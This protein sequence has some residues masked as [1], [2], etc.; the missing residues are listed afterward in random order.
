M[1]DSSETGSPDHAQELGTASARG[2]HIAAA[3][4]KAA[5]ELERRLEATLG[6]LELSLAKYGVLHSL[7]AAE[8]PL[9]LSDLAARLACV[10]SNITQLVD[11]LE[12]E[13]LVKRIDDPSDRRSVLAELTPK[14]Q[15]LERAG[16]EAIRSVHLEIASRVP[17]G[18]VP[19]LLRGLSSLE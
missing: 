2:A 18:G 19:D 3:I 4:R 17:E 10:R 5:A 9:A 13:G 6:R 14:G 15:D 1:P 16:A 7:A 11:R 8:Q 12:A